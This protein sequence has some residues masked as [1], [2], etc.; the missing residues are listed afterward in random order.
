MMVKF[1]KFNCWWI[2]LASIILSCVNYPSAACKV[3]E[4]LY[5][6]CKLTLVNSTLSIC[7]QT[8]PNCNKNSVP[9][10]EPIESYTGVP[11]GPVTNSMSATGSIFL[12]NNHLLL[13]PR[14][15]QN[16]CFHTGKIKSSPF[17]L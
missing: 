3:V 1:N 8:R 15:E 12:S 6:R 17:K 10:P 16:L 13:L 14:R 4:I 2:Y 5:F 9:E 7:T 11:V